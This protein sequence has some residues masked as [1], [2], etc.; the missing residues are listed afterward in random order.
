M[1]EERVLDGGLFMCR[2]AC[3]AGVVCH[4]QELGCWQ[5]QGAQVLMLN[6]PV[7]QQIVERRFLIDNICRKVCFRRYT[8]E[9]S[10]V[11]EAKDHQHS[12]PFSM[13]PGNALSP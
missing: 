12:C 5:T 3:I 8:P 4:R 13:V 11:L 6:Q 1:A 2:V 10:E 7:L 9:A